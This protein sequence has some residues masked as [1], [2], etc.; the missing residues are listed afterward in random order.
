[1]LLKLDRQGMTLH[2]LLHVPDK[3]ETFVRENAAQKQA[4]EVWHKLCWFA[5]LVR[6]RDGKFESD[7]TAHGVAAFVLQQISAVLRQ[8][9]R[10][11]STLLRLKKALH[12][13]YE[14]LLALHQDNMARHSRAIWRR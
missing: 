6:G 9:G 5:Q 13:P 14:V 12:T 2:D 1:M 4:G 11:K 10:L 8:S 3:M 7:W